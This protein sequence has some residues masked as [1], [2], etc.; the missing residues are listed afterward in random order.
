MTQRKAHTVHPG[1]TSDVEDEAFGSESDARE[2]DYYEQGGEARGMSNPGDHSLSRVDEPCLKDHESR[3]T[4]ELVVGSYDEVL[5]GLSVRCVEEDGLDAIDLL[6]RADAAIPGAATIVDIVGQYDYALVRFP[7][8]KS[9]KDLIPRKTPGYEG[10]FTFATYDKNGGVGGGNAAI[11]Q[12][13][14]QPAAIANLVMHS[15]SFALGLAYMARIDNKMGDIC[16]SIQSIQEYLEEDY[17]TSLE[18]DA[19]S[20]LDYVQNYAIYV[21]DEK[22]CA[23]IST[24]TEEILRN[25][26]KCWHKELHRMDALHRDMRQQAKSVTKAKAEEYLVRYASIDRRASLIL[27]LSFLA[28]LVRL[29]YNGDMSSRRIDLDKTAIAR[30]RDGYLDSR[31]GVSEELK[32]TARKLKIP[33]REALTKGA[34][35]G[36]ETVKSA[37]GAVRPRSVIAVGILVVIGIIKMPIRVVDELHN[38]AE[39]QKRKLLERFATTEDGVKRL[40]DSLE[41]RL[42]RIDFEYNKANAFLIDGHGMHPVEVVDTMDA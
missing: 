27:E 10:F 24:V 20:L 3:E 30:M 18:A 35:E 17:G 33:I 39:P 16:K 40:A 7:E 9:F 13:G 11:R 32:E 28:R 5:E 41:A 26:N 4:P 2:G 38:G 29:R 14:L 34:S 23:S 8:G 37:F 12:A 22:Q 31:E 1:D 6:A 25:L 19:D 15:A 42:E 21:D 36:L